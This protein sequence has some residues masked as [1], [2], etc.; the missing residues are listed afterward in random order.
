MERLQ[1][2]RMPL[3]AAACWFAAGVA[4]A[5]RW[6]PTGLLAIAVLALG[7]LVIVALCRSRRLA[8]LP[9]AALWIVAGAWCWQVHPVPDT[10]RNL[11]QYADGL[12]RNIH[13]HVI[14]V[15]KL[16]IGRQP[17]N[18]DSDATWQEEQQPEDGSI[19]SADIAIDAVEEVTPDIS[20]MVPARG[21]ARVTLLAKNEPL[22]E[23][24]CGD[25]IEVPLRLKIPERFNDPRVWQYADYLLAQGIG[26]RATSPAAKLHVVAHEPGLARCKLAA[27]QSWASDRML[28]YIHSAPNRHLPRMLRLTDDDAGMLNA[29][30]FGD[31]T[32]LT[33][34]LRSSFERT[35]SFHLF[36]VSGMHVALLGGMVLWGLRRLRIRDWAA[37]LIALSLMTGYA[38]VTGFGAPVQRALF[39]MAVFLCARLLSREQSILNAVGAAAL[40]ELVWA[41]G[42]LYEAS[43]QMTFLAVLAIA[44]IAVPLGERSFLPWARASKHL[45]ALWLDPVLPPRLAQLRVM[46]RLWGE[47]LSGVFGRWMNSLPVRFVSAALWLAELAL[48]GLVAELVMALPMTMYFHRATIFALPAN[49]FTIPMIGLLAPLAI[50][51][52]LLS[53]LAPSL[54]VVPAVATGGLLHSLGWLISRVSRFHSADLRVPGPVWWIALLALAGWMFCLWAIRRSRGWAVAGALLLPLGTLT[55]LWPEKPAISAGKLE[56]TAIDVGQGDSILV[57]SPD[58]HTMLIDAGG[59]VGR[60]GEVAEAANSFD[61]GEDVV[62]QYLWSRRLRQLDVLVLSHAHSDHMGGMPAVMCNLRPREL[63]GFHQ[64]GLRSLPRTSCRSGRVGSCCQASSRRRRYE[65][66]AGKG[67]GSRS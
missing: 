18:H 56:V 59:P 22:P 54:A 40:A 29:M 33:R 35:G 12:S 4:L 66:G 49:M 61:I 24:M 15:R 52:F 3:L 10:Q 48:I 17:A 50:A 67:Q 41:P 62:S 44:G 63:L 28:S 9:V 57:I 26:A 13:G 16:S 30:L 31:R 60:A 20:R 47:L 8:I 65:P 32:R 1:F 2:R 37:T 7:I 43:F 6:I 39:M 36:V 14:R 34:Q 55:V 11:L 25:V 51:L 58:G 21:G 19:L 45:S 5:H 27:A 53:L 42:S 64:S 23:L 38:L 46:L